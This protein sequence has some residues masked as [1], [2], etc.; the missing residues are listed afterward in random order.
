VVSSGMFCRVGFVDVVI[1]VWY[2]WGRRGL[3]LLAGAL[4]VGL[5]ESENAGTSEELSES[6]V[7]C[8]IP[9]AKILDVIQLAAMWKVPMG[10]DELLRLCG[11]EG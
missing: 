1:A 11:A 8:Q 7:G 5:R 6:D 3:A 4:D 2:G 9:Y 10:M